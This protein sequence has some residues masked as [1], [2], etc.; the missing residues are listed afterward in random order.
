M[1]ALSNDPD[2]GHYEHLEEE[3]I[4]V[5]ILL[6]LAQNVRLLTFLRA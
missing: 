3:R 6:R 1:T 4:G 2:S 5:L